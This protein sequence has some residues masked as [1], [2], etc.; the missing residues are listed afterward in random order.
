VNTKPTSELL[1]PHWPDTAEELDALARGYQFTMEHEKE[2]AKMAERQ[3][4]FNRTNPPPD[5]GPK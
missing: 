5:A 4:E 3:R 1:P 2:K